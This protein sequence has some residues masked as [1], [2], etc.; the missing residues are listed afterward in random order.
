MI[1]QKSGSPQ[2]SSDVIIVSEKGS[3]PTD[4]VNQIST[5]LGRELFW[6][7]SKFTVLG[8]N[9]AQSG[10]ALFIDAS[11]RS[12]QTRPDIPLLITKGTASSIIT[13]VTK[14]EKI[15][16]TSIER[17]LKEQSIIGY[18]PV[19]SRLD[20]TNLLTGKSKAPI[21][22]VINFQDNDI[23]GRN[24]ELA[25]TAVFNKDKLI[26]YLNKNE[27]R[28]LN[29]IRGKVKSG[30][31]VASLSDGSSIV[32]DIVKTKSKVYPVVTNG[33]ITMVIDIKEQGNIRETIANIDPMSKPELM[34]ELSKIQNKAIEHEINLVLQKA[35]KELKSDIFDFAGAIHR[36]Y[37][38]VW[39]SIENNWDETF[40]N[41]KIKI[42][43]NSSIKRPGVIS[44]PFR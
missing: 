26:G 34:D 19:I 15:S 20:F 40:P 38:K 8:E 4:A 10:T 11:L 29:W 5:I 21:A 17:L 2:G 33:D 44:K 18:S 30:G 42:N 25:G 7:H 13:S 36:D 28:G 1:G 3:T 9:L 22:A 12:N 23:T 32:F 39:K 24:L 43:V 35:Q 27:T 6:A 16:A 41:I 31:L 37:P 14:N